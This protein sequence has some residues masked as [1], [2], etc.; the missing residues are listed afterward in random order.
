M[1]MWKESGRDLKVEAERLAQ[2]GEGPIPSSQPP[3]H[4]F[5]SVFTATSAHLQQSGMC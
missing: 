3:P 1:Y 4:L 5:L 2:A